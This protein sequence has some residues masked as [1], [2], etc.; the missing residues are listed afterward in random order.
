MTLNPQDEARVDAARARRH[1]ESLHRSKPH[2]CIDRTTQ[3]HRGQRCT[4]TEMGGHQ[5]KFLSRTAEEVAGSST[6]PGVAQPVES[7]ASDPPL[8]APVSGDRIGGSLGRHGSMKCRV[9]TGYLGQ[10]RV[11]GSQGVDRYQALGIVQGSQIGKRLEDGVRSIVDEDGLDERGTTVDHSVAHRNNLG[12]LVEERGQGSFQFRRFPA[13]KSARRHQLVLPVQQTQSQ[14][15][16]SSVD[17]EDVHLP[18]LPD[19]TTPV[20]MMRIDTAIHRRRRR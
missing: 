18:T 14:A 7:E 4:C 12:V 17:D 5:A 10:V 9:E 3:R 15:A 6:G 1:H 19:R 2:G 8:L 20:R 11:Q 16:G 13:R